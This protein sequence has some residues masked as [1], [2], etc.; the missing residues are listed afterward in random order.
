MKRELLIFGAAMLLAGCAATN[1]R[2]YQ[3]S[4]ALLSEPLAMEVYSTGK[5]KPK[6]ARNQTPAGKPLKSA[7]VTYERGLSVMGD[8]I[9][10]Y[11]MDSEKTTLEMYVC[12]D[13]TSPKE[14]KAT[15]TVSGN[16]KTIWEKDLKKSSFEEVKQIFKG[17]EDLVITVKGD[18]EAV[19]DFLEPKL[20]GGIKLRETMTFGR[21]NY[22][23][24][25]KLDDFHPFPTEEKQG[26]VV[27]CRSSYENYGPVIGVSNAYACAMVAPYHHGMLVHY[28]PNS[29]KTFG[30]T[31]QSFLQPEEEIVPTRNYPAVVAD[32]KR[33]KWR[34]EEDGAI[35]V[36]AC[37]D[38]LNGV[39][40]MIVYRL[41]P[42]SGELTVDAMSKNITK[43]DVMSCLSL[44][45]RFPRG[46]PVA[47]SAEK[48]RPGYSLVKGSDEG[49]VAKDGVVV[50]NQL[51]DWYPL[52]GP[53]KL[54]QKENGDFLLIEKSGYFKSESLAPK[55][56]YYPYDGLKL[57]LYNSANGVLV[58]QYGEKLK[59][60][61]SQ[62]LHLRVKLDLVG[63]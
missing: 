35:R 40:R 30:G 42:R 18:P 10:C 53:Q 12:M 14:A 4:H 57:N 45:T 49:I 19:V 6:F 43:H 62:T 60:T 52:K 34:I 9:I 24:Q 2:V 28:G 23:A 58:T 21:T 22:A 8:A 27:F 7:G 13:E 16:G 48:A 15:V 37:P 31:M 56:G 63:Y 55:N 44:T 11:A 20:E 36:L 1:E 39:R 26:V 29:Q 5:A 47:I 3:K 51:E 46:Y 61:N 54:L 25:C 17:T 59:M 50:I 33:W 41:D 32:T 38:L